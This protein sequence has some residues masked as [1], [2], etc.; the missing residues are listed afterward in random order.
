MRDVF[1]AVSQW[2]EENVPFALA[3]LVG[4]RNAAPAPL[5]ATMAVSGDGRIAGDI[6]AGCHEGEIVAAAAATVADSES[7]LLEIDLTSDD[8]VSGGSGC[9][10]F[11]EVATWRPSPSFAQTA[12]AIA[13]GHSD[14]KFSVAYEREGVAREFIAAVPARGE[15]IV[16]GGTTLAQDLASI[17]RSLDFRTVVVDPRPAFA[18]RERLPAVDE[19]IVA[20][21]DEA[22]PALLSERTP[23]IVISH[24]PKLDIPALCCG[25][26][27]DAPYVGLLGSR[28]AQASRRA[29]LRGDGFQEAALDRIH[30]PSGLDLG[31]VSMAETAVSILAEII[32]TAHGRAGGSL[33]RRSGA[34]HNAG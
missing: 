6:G 20:W 33:L 31:S 24:D 17:G 21:P 26:Q 2:S 19:I 4:V 11:L 3:T 34:I 7:R 18:T 12:G 29:A 15:L 16:V 1:A 22:L 30:G 27:S 13:A 28:R 25:L 23:L 10:G 14:V 8:I 5:G 9:G 32:A